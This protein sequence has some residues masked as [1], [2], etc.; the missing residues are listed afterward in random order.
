MIS[1]I[2]KIFYAF[3]FLSVFV[4]CSAGIQITSKNT[5]PS[6]GNI[7]S[8]YIAHNLIKKSIAEFLNKSFEKNG[9]QSTINDTKSQNIDS[10]R[11]VALSNNSD[12]LIIIQDGEVEVK[13]SYRNDDGIYRQNCQV[14][15]F[16][17]ECDVEIYVVNISLYKA[18]DPLIYWNAKIE[19]GNAK[20]KK[21]SEALIARMK[22]DRI[23]NGQFKPY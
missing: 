1:L 23:L 10:L 19:I 11:N 22:E 13:K 16:S 18:S 12:Y 4:N 21:I 2:T 3:L 6:T 14:F 17:Q 20:G 5:Q 15:L 9:K 7:E 8:I